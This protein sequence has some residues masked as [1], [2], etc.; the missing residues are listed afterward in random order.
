MKS[1]RTIFA[2]LALA[3]A[4]LAAPFVA[5]IAHL[6]PQAQAQS[7]SDHGENKI[8]DA[9]LRAQALG[10]PATG[11]IALY[12][13]GCN[14]AGGG[15]EVSGGSYARVAVTASLANWAGTQSA[16]STTASTGTG[17]QTSNNAA[18]TFP[19]PSGGSWGS[20]TH[21]S[22]MSASSGGDMW[23]CQALTQAK[24]VNDGDSAPSFAIGAMTFTFQ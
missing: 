14:D 24:T 17:G 6:A 4:V 5:P 10:A 1:F 22:Y 13:S 11:Y 3:L 16:G 23:F 2:G 18:I 7:L 9:V 20:I 19:A 21:F 12:T 15:A 8:I